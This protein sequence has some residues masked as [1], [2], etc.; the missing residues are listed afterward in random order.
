[1]ARTKYRTGQTVWRL[2]ENTEDWTCPAC[3]G[4]GIFGFERVVN[5]ATG[6]YILKRTA[7]K[8]KIP[9]ACTSCGGTGKREVLSCLISR[10]EVELDED[11]NIIVW[12]LD[13][14]GHDFREEFLYTTAEEALS[15]RGSVERTGAPVVSR[16]RSLG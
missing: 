8:K 6:R 1:M 10:I 9:R 12:Y 5:P 3:R 2:P 11:D 7:G 13:N 15:A 4:T 14:R 16:Q